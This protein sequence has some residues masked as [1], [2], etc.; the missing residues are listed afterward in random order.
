MKPVFKIFLFDKEKPKFGISS[1][2]SLNVIFELCFLQ[3]SATSLTVKVSFVKLNVSDDKPS[4]NIE[5][6]N[7]RDNKKSIN[8][9]M[10]NFDVIDLILIPI[11]EGFELSLIKIIT[12]SEIFKTKSHLRAKKVRNNLIDIAQLHINDL[13]VHFLHGIGR[14]LGL[15]TININSKFQWI[16]K[17]LNSVLIKFMN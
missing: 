17:I 4:T 7:Y 15:K 1:F 6:A 10:D 5:V 8:E 9:C 11:N 13:V 14:Y 12:L 2:V 3:I 16:S